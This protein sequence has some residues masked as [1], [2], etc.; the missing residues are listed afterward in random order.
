MLIFILY[1]LIY[2][3]VFYLFIPILN[4]SEFGKKAFIESLEVVSKEHMFSLLFT[5]IWNIIASNFLELTWNAFQEK[6]YTF[7]LP[8]KRKYIVSFLLPI[9]LIYYFSAFGYHFYPL[10]PE[11]FGGG[12]PREVR[13]ILKNDDKTNVDN[14]NSDLK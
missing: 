4:L 5:C 13:I 7:L 1:I 9:I 10:I 3:L 2:F 12:K 8:K 11:Q 6:P 14:I